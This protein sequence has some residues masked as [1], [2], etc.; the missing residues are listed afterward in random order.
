MLT[1]KKTSLVLI[2]LLFLCQAYGQISKKESAAID[3]IL[4]DLSRSNKP[5]AYVIKNVNI[6][7]MTDPVLVTNRSVLIEGGFIKKIDSNIDTG[8]VTVIDGSGKFLMPGLTDMHVH[9]FDRHP[10]KNTWILLLLVHGVTS[11][12]DMCGEPGKLILRE[13]IRRNEI[14]APNLYQAGPLIN[15]KDNSFLSVAASTPEHG[16]EVVVRQKKEGYDMVKVYDGLTRESY[17]AIV[18]EA[19]KQGML[20]DGHV[21]DQ[22]PIAELLTVKHNSIE[23]LTGYFEWKDHQVSLT[24]PDNYA[25]L[26][27]NSGVW[28]CPT[29]YNHYMNGSRQGASE[30]IA[31]AE[32]SGLIPSELRQTWK[33]RIGSHSKAIVEIVDKYGASN[34]EAFKKIVL[35]L[36]RANAK[37]IAGTDAGS[38]PLL[39]PGYSL[40]NELKM[41]HE[42][43]IPEEDVLKMTTVNAACALGRSA[44]FGT[45]EVGKRADLL[46]LHD[47]PLVNLV[48]L[49]RKAGLFIRGVFLPEGEIKKIEDSIRMAFGN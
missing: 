33:D 11:V 37:L 7:T 28:N 15:G 47:N 34:F 1:L 26:T 6:L 17:R 48:N 40:H 46:L 30:M 14:L 25:L 41:L 23:H 9:L 39:I 42:I 2:S 45:V 16:R 32:T 27:A 31:Y 36:Y 8:N 43:G 44:E 3:N 38:L 5:Q 10:L 19:N 21:P 13:K 4:A 35:S 18:D 12:R 49:D 24:A 29:I 20:V 22:I